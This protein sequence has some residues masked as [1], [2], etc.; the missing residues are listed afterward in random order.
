[1]LDN[2]CDVVQCCLGARFPGRFNSVVN[3]TWM[4]SIQG[5]IP[6]LACATLGQLGGMDMQTPHRKNMEFDPRTF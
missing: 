1:M 5:I 3:Y 4:V 2:E 6:D